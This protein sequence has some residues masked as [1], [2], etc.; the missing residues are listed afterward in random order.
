MYLFAIYREHPIDVA[1]VA[2][3]G[4]V[5]TPKSKIVSFRLSQEEYGRYRSACPAVGARSLSELARVAIERLTGVS[6]PPPVDPL[7]R[8]LDAKV[9]VLAAELERL[10]Q[11]VGASKGEA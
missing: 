4:R 7:V 6:N 1:K 10:S 2:E 11:I 3:F 5:V 8:A 9:R